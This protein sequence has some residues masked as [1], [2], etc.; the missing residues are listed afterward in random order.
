MDQNLDSTW[1]MNCMVSFDKLEIFLS[2]MCLVEILINFDKSSVS[3]TN[4][5]ILNY[6]KFCLNVETIE[7]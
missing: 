4:D 2:M 3:T 6:V 5:L 7:K 1:L